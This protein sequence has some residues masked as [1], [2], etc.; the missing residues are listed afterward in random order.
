M[1]VLQYVL[2]VAVG[3]VAVTLAVA[4]ILPVWFAGVVLPSA[5]GVSMRIG[6]VLV[7]LTAM[8]VLFRDRSGR[9]L[10]AA[11]RGFVVAGVIGGLVGFWSVYRT[12]PGELENFYGIRV[13]VTSALGVLMA[14][15]SGAWM[16][17]ALSHVR[18]RRRTGAH[19]GASRRGDSRDGDPPPAPP[20]P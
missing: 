10:V 7:P 9:R 17:L 5:L 11:S 4:A 14:G 18:R 16:V 2:N 13:V 1:R 15:L 20:S 12:P 6:V 8:T 19:E 3:L